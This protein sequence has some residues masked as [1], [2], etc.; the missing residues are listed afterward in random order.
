MVIHI[1][2]LNYLNIHKDIGVVGNEIGS[3]TKLLTLE[4]SD[5]NTKPLIIL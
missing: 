4:R 2:N 5:L 1:S 3:S